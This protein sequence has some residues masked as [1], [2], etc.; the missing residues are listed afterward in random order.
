M[1][2][3]TM[4]CLGRQGRWGNQVLE[5]TFLRAYADRYGLDY[6][7]NPWIGQ[8]LFG[9]CDPPVTSRLPLYTER[10]TFTAGLNRMTDENIYW[11]HTLPPDS[12]EVVDHDF[13][14]YAQFHTSYYFSQ[15]QFIRNQFRS[16]VPKLGDRMAPAVA[17][18]RGEGGTVIG[19]HM[20]RGDTGHAVFYLTP[21][22]WY[23]AWLKE[24][25]GRFDRPRL[26]IATEEPSDVEAFRKY[27][28]VAASS[29]MSL[30]TDRYQLYNYLRCDLTSPTAETMDWFPD[31]WLLRHCDVMLIGE[32]TFSFTAAMMNPHLQECWRSMLSKQEF[33]QIEPWDSFPLVREYLHDYPGIPGTFYEDNPKWGAGEVLPVQGSTQ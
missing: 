18:L 15:R 22:E 33:V 31:W 28:P 7:N 27:N 11:N 26:F 25:W 23:L 3:I 10:N 20:R 6:Q 17:G 14:G 4:E 24:H 19:L 2:M 12:R 30:E 16:L 13:R 1:S 5:Y 21:N 9:H 29:L 32:S 8:L